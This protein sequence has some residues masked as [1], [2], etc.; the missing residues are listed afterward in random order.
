M[1]NELFSMQVIFKAVV[2][3]DLLRISVNQ[4]CLW[5]IGSTYDVNY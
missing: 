2:Y 5:M 1:L 4:D 3:E